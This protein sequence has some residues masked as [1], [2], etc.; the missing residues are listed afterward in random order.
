MKKILKL[1]IIGCGRIAGCQHIPRF[2]AIDGV[3]ITA[4]C[5]TNTA[6]MKEQRRKS[7]PD[8]ELFSDYRQL[9]ERGLDAVSICTPNDLHCSITL[10]A[11]RAGLHVMCEKPLAGRLADANRMV[12]AARRAGRILQVNQSLRYE[13]SFV[14]LA[15]L[16][17]DGQIG[18]PIHARCIRSFGATPDKFWSPGA[19]WFVSRKR[20]GGIVL[21]IGVHIADVLQW[22]MGDI[23]EVAA[24]TRTLTSGIDATDTAAAL[25]RCRNGG[26]AM[27]EL[28]WATPVPGSLMEVYGTA[29]KIRTGFTKEPIELTRIGRKGAEVSYPKIE[30]NVPS[31]F[32]CFVRAIRSGTRSPTP[33]EL[34]RDS[35]AI[36][37]AIEEAGRSKRFVR[38][39]KFKS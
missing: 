15:G 13:P 29:G 37:L 18:K 27:L 4:L 1:G 26:T 12:T 39:K 7:A 28:S 2:S 9:L 22:I 25:F 3:K 31:S 8:A 30:K 5:D 24:A 21:D 23:V 20:Q 38:I 17:A 16:V 34:G 33:G 14:T 32:D 11:L 35:V 6:R 36:C 10:A 19:K